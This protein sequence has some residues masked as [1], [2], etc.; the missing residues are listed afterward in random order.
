MSPGPPLAAVLVQAPGRK[1]G[2]SDQGRYLDQLQ[3]Q[4]IHLALPGPLL[5]P[6][7]R[8]GLALGALPG[9]GLGGGLRR[10]AA[11]DV[12]ADAPTADA[13]RPGVVRPPP[14]PLFPRHAL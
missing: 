5:P 8:P 7:R 6:R 14:W 12:F 13:P 10:R 4:V 1:G 9:V 2:V 3:D 11:A